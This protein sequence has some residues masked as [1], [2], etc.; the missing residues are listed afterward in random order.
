MTAFFLEAFRMGDNRDMMLISACLAGK[1]CKYNGGDNL[2]PLFLRL[3]EEGQARLVCPE[4]LGG[5]PVPRSPSEIRGGSGEDV[6]D[7]KARVINKQGEDVSRQ[8][9]A[10]ADETLQIARQAGAAQV[11][12]KSRSPSCGRGKIYDGSFSGKL[13]SGDGVAT[14]LLRRHGVEVISDEEYLQKGECSK[15]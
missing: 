8:F 9:L 15:N 4:E 3:V 13:C 10:G 5:L 1:K 2:H 11:I 14:A 12:F 6:L 7:G